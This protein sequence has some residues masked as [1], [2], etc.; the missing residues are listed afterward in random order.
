MEIIYLDKVDSTQKY[1]KEYIKKQ[2]IKSNIAIVT[3]DQTDGIGSKENSWQGIKGNLYFSFTQHI[4]QL[5]QDLKLQSASIYFSF[6]LKEVLKKH[7]S[8]V[9]IKWPNDFYLDNKK[10]GGTI[11]H[12]VDDLLYCGIGLN[13]VP[14]DESY[15][16]LDIQIDKA[17]ILDDYFLSLEEKPSWKKVFSQFRI[18]YELS[19]NFKATFKDRKISLADSVLLE[20]GSILIENEKVYSLR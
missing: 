15:G 2:N 14:I 9:W 13:I 4:S 11:T 6:L 10:I 16:C 3:D 18:E 8:K 17:S 20:D 7:N 5:P 12:L 1:L 19:R